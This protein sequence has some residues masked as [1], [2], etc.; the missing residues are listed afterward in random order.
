ML[1]SS[2]VT[3][4]RIMR[5]SPR[6]SHSFITSRKRLSLF[7]AV[8]SHSKGSSSFS[9]TKRFRSCRIR[10]VEMRTMI[11]ELHAERSDMRTMIS[12]LH[13]VLMPWC[14]VVHRQLFSLRIRRQVMDLLRLSPLLQLLPLRNLNHPLHPRLQAGYQPGAKF[15]QVPFKDWGQRQSP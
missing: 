7:K 10:F 11:S 9:K 14:Q 1:R 15:D 12:D 8:F 6:H 13:A 2:F 3:V 4:S 5:K